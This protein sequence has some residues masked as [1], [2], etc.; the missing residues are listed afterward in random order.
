MK[1]RV[2][3]QGNVSILGEMRGLIDS[4]AGGMFSR[5]DVAG[6]VAYAKAVDFNMTRV[7][8]L[9]PLLRDV[10]A[11]YGE[12]LTVAM[13]A[14]VRA[15]KFG[16]AELAERIGLRL[17][18][19]AVLAISMEMYGKRLGQLNEEQKEAV[20]VRAA[21]E[22]LINLRGGE[23]QAIDTAAGSAKRLKTVWQEILASEVN[24]T[25]MV[26]LNNS[27]ADVL[28]GLNAI[29]EWAQRHPHAAALLGMPMPVQKPGKPVD[30]DVTFDLPRAFEETG[31]ERRAREAEAEFER[32]KQEMYAPILAAAAA[33]EAYATFRASILEKAREDEETARQWARYL[34]EKFGGYLQDEFSVRLNELQMGPPSPTGVPG[35]TLGPLTTK[36]SDIT[37]FRLQ[38]LSEEEY[39]KW[40]RQAWAD[41]GAW[42]SASYGNAI[43]QMSTALSFLFDRQVVTQRKLTHI[44][45]YAGKSFAASILS[46]IGETA[47]QMAMY[48]LAMAAAAA[49]WFTFGPAS[50]GHHL[51]SAALFG[52][53]AAVA[54]GLGQTIG[55]GAQRELAGIG[56]EREPAAGE[57]TRK[58]EPAVT[59]R[60]DLAATIAKAPENVFI[61]VT[62]IFEGPNVIGA[63]ANALRVFYDDHIRDWV[64]DDARAGEIAA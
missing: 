20:V 50:I 27:L 29:S 8:E 57:I 49:G 18:E 17:R 7:A 33:E 32:R 53:V 36:T 19:N 16:E 60:R 3:A 42:I 41:H 38:Q 35:I 23:A 1:L 25:G 4:S 30:A 63:D 5:S 62:T 37:A 51:R 58:G 9:L 64:K 22:Q 61:H 44:W 40:S 59:S 6:A 48:N 2:L 12:D 47:K 10:S 56:Y 54:G 26:A 55:R 28:G 24:T 34:G 21:I 31:A 46:A 43:D 11:M 15:A 14:I 45:N 13:Q 39:L 52:A